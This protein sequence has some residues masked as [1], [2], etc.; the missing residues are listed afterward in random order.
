M[1]NKA[2]IDVVSSTEDN[3]NDYVAIT[4]TTGGIILN[5]GST[6]TF[7]PFDA[8]PIE[9]K[10]LSEL[11]VQY[12]VDDSLTNKDV[13]PTES[14]I[15]SKPIIEETT[16]IIEETKPIIEE[17]KPIIEETTAIIEETK[18]IIKETSSVIE[19]TVQSQK[20]LNDY[21][22]EDKIIEFENLLKDIQSN[23]IFKL[24]NQYGEFHLKTLVKQNVSQYTLI[25]PYGLYLCKKSITVNQIISDDAHEILDEFI[26]FDSKYKI[27]NEKIYINGYSRDKYII[28]IEDFNIRNKINEQLEKS[29]K[30]LSEIIGCSVK[31][32]VSK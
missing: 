25:F 8:I 27:V 4:K 6:K 17:T 19:Q 5:F 15:E 1:S 31:C 11:D 7:V 13:K 32:S 10:K 21:I 2:N 20:T 12:V 29:E 24:R 23:L 30:M 26:N 9:E 16:P 22:Q 18:P 3:T 28:S 14:V